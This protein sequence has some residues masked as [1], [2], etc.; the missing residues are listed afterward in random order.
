MSKQ[1]SIT[2]PVLLDDLGNQTCPPNVTNL[3]QDGHITIDIS[4]ECTVKHGTVCN[5]QPGFAC[6]T[7]NVIL[8]VKV[9]NKLNN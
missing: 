3:H 6:I 5:V 1:H 2:E 8:I 7:A 4:N 9:S